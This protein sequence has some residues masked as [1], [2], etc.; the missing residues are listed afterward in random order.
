[1]TLCQCKLAFSLAHVS[2]DK[3]SR[4]INSITDTVCAFLGSLGSMTTN[5][6]DP[7]HHHTAQGAKRSAAI[8]VATIAAPAMLTVAFACVLSGDPLPK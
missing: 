4:S 8:I 1:M 5:K 6:I 2:D 7:L 3:G